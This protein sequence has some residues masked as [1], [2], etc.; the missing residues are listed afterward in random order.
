MLPVQ[1]DERVR[2]VFFIHVSVKTLAVR[3]EEILFADINIVMQ[4]GIF[5]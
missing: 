3:F 1:F 4:G 2:E 5:R